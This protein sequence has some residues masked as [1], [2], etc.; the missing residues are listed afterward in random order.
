MSSRLLFIAFAILLSA[1]AVVPPSTANTLHGAEILTGQWHG[2]EVHYLDGEIL[3]GLKVGNTQSDFVRELD[4][5]D[6]EIV[7]QADPL[8]FLKLK[9]RD[10]KKLFEIIDRVARLSSVK[11]AEPNMVNHTFVIP[12][13]PDFIKQWHYNNTGQFPPGGTPDADIDAPEGWDIS[14][15]SHTVRVGVLDT[16]IPMENGALSHPDLDDPL[17]YLIGTDLINGDD[18]PLDDNGHGTH[19]TGTIAAE[20]NNG[21]GVA[22][23]AWNVQTLS[24]KVFDRYGYGSQE[25]FRDGCIYATDNGC[26]VINYSGG[27]PAS[28]TTEAGVS[29]AESHN[30]VICAAAGND[31]HGPVSYPG[32]YSPSHSNLI[33]VSATNPDDS[34]SEFSSIGPEVTISAPGGAGLPFDDDDVW[35]TF[36]NYEVQL[37]IDYDLP[38]NYGPLAGTSMATPHVAG[39]AALILSVAPNI[40]A[41]SVKHLIMNT[42]DDLG[43]P[44]F[45]NYFGW[46]RI[47]VYNALSQVAAVAIAH[48]PLPDTK[49]TTNDYEVLCAIFSDTTLVADSLLL[50]YEVGSIW[51]TEVLQA[52]GG[53][54]EYHAYIAAQSPGTV[55]DYYLFAKN[56]RG[57]YD[58]TDVHTF[59][60]I[61]YGVKLS[62]SFQN[63]LGGV[64]ETVWYTVTL[65]NDGIYTDSFAVLTTAAVWQTKVWDSTGSNEIATVGPL[66]PDESYDLL[67]SV[68]VPSSMYGNLDSARVVASSKSTI[69]IFDN[70]WVRTMSVGQPLPIPFIELFDSPAVD[71]GKWLDNE[72]AQINELGLNPPSEPYSLDLNGD[73]DGGDLIATQPID[74]TGLSGLNVTFSYERTGAGEEPDEGDDLTVEYMNDVGEW[75]LFAQ[76]LGGQGSMTEF[77][78]VTIPVPADG[79]HSGFRL[80]FSVTATEG[81]YDDWFIDDVRI[82]WGPAISV[83]PNTYDFSLAPGDSAQD[84]LVVDNAGPGTLTYSILVS[85]DYS[86]MPAFDLLYKTGQVNPASY[87]KPDGWTP[88]L[89]V[90]GGDEGPA[91]PEVIYNA[92]GPDTFGYVWLDSDQSN[93][94]SFNWVNILSTGTDVTSGLDDDNVIGPFPIGFDFPF[95]DSTYSEF[96]ITSNGLIGFGPTD[97]Y[98]SVSNIPIPNAATPNN[99]IAWCWDDLDPTDADIPDVKVVYENAGGG[100]VIQFH[101]YPEYFADPGDVINF[102]MILYPNGWVRLQYLSVA[103]GFDVSGCT[104]GSENAE[105]TDGLQVVYNAA[106]LHDSLCVELIKPADWLYLSSLGGQLPPEAADTIAVKITTADLDTGWYKNDISVRSNDPD[107]EDSPWMVTAQL[108]V[109]PQGPSYVC[110]DADGNDLVNISDA[111]YLVNYIFGG[112]DAPDPLLAAD[113]DCDGIVN[114]SDAV[115]LVGY[116]FGGGPAPC[117][118]CD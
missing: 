22:G 14:T 43:T 5:R 101:D 13:D 35:S 17:R 97:N 54:K 106:C 79:Y 118:V 58:S 55:V 21:I 87:T 84:V 39:L 42:S 57:E 6:A 24:I 31:Y 83:A 85:P 26:R 88:F 116:I 18:E 51:S 96:Y 81:P 15:G 102:E 70:A 65:T 93:G 113:A 86:F 34:S 8:G 61:D 75:V 68:T 27:G 38:Q 104:V 11:Y 4:S 95:Y 52:T 100:L 94:P 114:I 108:Y 82:D 117:A 71:I 115:Y 89:G 64:D 91:G 2:Q 23:V 10:S 72:G 1:F 67:V 60:V 30:V 109:E 36:P 107:P 47:N 50:H 99:I 53:D 28:S 40:S 76:Y 112:G 98:N 32:A 62:P 19:V 111:V 37:N 80:R 63:S 44:G 12:N 59:R 66:L 46:G 73:P 3:V 103:A 25:A 49:D 74:L 16:G 110:G 9:A 20:S 41:D 29:Y 69:G 45:D 7:R 105:G 92:G 33:C 78:P 48:Q 77:E 90:K 56:A